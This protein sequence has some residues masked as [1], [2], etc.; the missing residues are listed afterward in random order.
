MHTKSHSLTHTHTHS[1]LHKCCEWEPAAPVPSVH[2]ASWTVP[3]ADKWAVQRSRVQ[4]CD[5]TVGMV[6]GP[7]PQLRLRLRTR[8]RP[9]PWP[10]HR[11]H[12]HKWAMPGPLFLFLSICHTPWKEKNKNTFLRQ[13]KS[14]SEREG[15]RWGG[16]AAGKGL[17][18]GPTVPVC[19]NVFFGEGVM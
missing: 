2:V 14:C 3:V 10:P 4:P 1:P 7:R 8:P 15:E 13:E 6:G 12:T 5:H 19:L 18:E 17:S 16:W 9:K 11:Q